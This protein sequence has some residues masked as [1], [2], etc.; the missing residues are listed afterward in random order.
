[1]SF[2]QQQRSGRMGVVVLDRPTAL[3]ALDTPMI[4]ELA[5]VLEGWGEDPSVHAVVLVSATERAFCAGGDVRAV[6][7]ASLAG[8]HAAVEAFFAGEYALNLAIAIYPKPVVSLIDGLC[9][10]GGVGLSV[11]GAVR[12]ATEHASVAMPETAIAL[13]PDVG[14]SHALPRMPGS[15][16]IYLALTGARMQ[17]ADAVHA[18]FATHFVLR[19]ELE[20]LRAALA[21]DGVAVLAEFAAPLPAFSLAAQRAVIDQC[22]SA[23]SIAEIRDRLARDGSDFAQKTLTTLAEKSPSSLAWS[24]DLL[25]A[26]ETRTLPQCLQAELEMTRWVTRHPDFIEGVRAMVVDKDRTPIWAAA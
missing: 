16:G 24:L 23:G 7:A 22:F 2:V 13:F 18:G 8:D 1:M 12:V 10:G 5:A 4:S 20:A 14:T 3:N 21:A 19:T 9:L 25:R 26:G 17:G 6:R 15:L 11:H